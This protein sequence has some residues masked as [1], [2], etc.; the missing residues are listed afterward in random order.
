MQ[1]NEFIEA[2]GKLEI[3]YGKELTTEQMQIMFEELNNLSIERY[4]KLISKCLKTCKYMPKIADIYAANIELIGETEDKNE[5]ITTACKKC[6]GTGYVVYTSFINNGNTRI[7][8]TYAAK[9]D[10]ENSK[11][12]SE[13][14]P[15]YLELGIQ[16]SNRI[17][18]L[19]DTNRSIEYIKSNLVEKFKV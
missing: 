17:N 14:I 5:R 3:Y 15:S 2:T 18:Q 9:C 13:K 1:I 7:P 12:A 10:C 16:V 4:K 19:K 8:Y 11:Y 6:D